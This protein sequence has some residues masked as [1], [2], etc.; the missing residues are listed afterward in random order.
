MNKQLLDNWDFINS[1]VK[2]QV[3]KR[4]FKCGK[5]HILD[6][7]VDHVLF[8]VVKES[9][10]FNSK[11][12]AIN[13]WIYHVSKYRTIDFLIKENAYSKK[14][15][16]SFY[17][18]V[19]FEDLTLEDM[20]KLTITKFDFQDKEFSKFIWD[21]FLPSILTNRE[22]DL[23][24]DR[25]LNSMKFKDIGEK[26]GFKESYASQYHKKVLNTIRQAINRDS[27]LKMELLR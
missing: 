9:V 20:E 12:S 14:L 13:T 5:L 22:I 2:A 16:K 26:L 27:K 25:Y 4:L 19:H 6:E 1:I 17:K 3:N 7:V 23:L 21:K 11:K 8:C 18:P 15:K 24:R 10:R